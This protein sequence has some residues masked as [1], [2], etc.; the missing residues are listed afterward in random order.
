MPDPGDSSIIPLMPAKPKLGLPGREVVRESL[1][2]ITD[3]AA[4]DLYSQ[5]LA[6]VRA[7]GDFHLALSGGSTP[8]PLYRRLMVDPA[9][10]E[11]PWRKTHLWIVDERRVPLDH[12][13]SNYRMIAETLVDQAD[14]PSEQVHPM[15]ATSAKAADLYEAELRRVLE[16]REKG[17]DR[18]DYVLLGVGTDGHTASLFPR[19]PALGASDRLVAMND[20]PSVT[21]PPRVTMTYRLLNAS[22]FVGVLVTGAKKREVLR[23]IAAASKG[24]AG[25]TDA[26]AATGQRLSTGDLPVLGIKPLAGEL[27]WYMDT[28]AVG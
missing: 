12:E 13:L 5:A 19:S 11:L 2:E 21:P 26:T 27:R 6:C 28:E 18:L 25:T 17:H 9:F 1:E 16:W 10:R 8:E 15:Q 4:A 24:V 14:I 7:F 20:G 22:R 23:K 3:A